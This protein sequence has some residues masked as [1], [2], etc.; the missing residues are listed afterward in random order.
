M[1]ALAHLSDPHLSPLPQP[2]LT[3]LFGKRLVGY[4]N[5]KLRRSKHHDAAALAAIEGDLRAQKPNHIAVLGDLI[6][7][8]LPAEYPPA[9]AFLARLGSPQDVTLVP[10]NHD[11]YVRSQAL[12]Y[13]KAWGDYI[14]GDTAA[15][16]TDPRFPFVRRRGPVALIGLC[17]GHPTLPFL[18]TGTLGKAQLE[19][20]RQSLSAIEREGLFRIVLI[21]HPPAGLRPP[22]KVLTDAAAFLRCHRRARRRIGSP[23][24]R[25]QAFATGAR[26]SARRCAADRCAVGL[27]SGRRIGS[28]PPGIFIVSAARRAHGTVR[29][30]RAACLRR[31]PST[32]ARKQLIA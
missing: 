32:L 11:S 26:R 12:T 29:W 24:T 17:T 7:L 28:R 2:G 9:T 10:G 3:E 1:F 19:R 21:H 14:Q 16:G 23:R 31:A 20:P 6:N 30:K 8:C 25:P 18:A 4:V 5:W 13:R 15:S 27:E 22:H